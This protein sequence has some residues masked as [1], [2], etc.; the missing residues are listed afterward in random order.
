MERRKFIK[1]TGC[2]TLFVAG[3]GALA[4]CSSPENKE[5]DKLKTQALAAFNRYKEVWDFDNFWRRGNTFDACLVFA[6]AARNR[7]PDDKEVV[8]MQHDIIEMLRKNLAYFNSLDVTDMWADDFGWW[9]LM[10]LNARKHLLRTGDTK[11]AGEYFDLA[12]NKCWE[13]KKN[14]AYDETDNAIPV[15][16]GCSNGDA[17]GTSKGVKNTVTNVLLFLLSSRIYR[18][19]KEEKIS[20][21]DK[22]LDMA[23]KQWV[24]F[25]SWFKLKQ[26]EYLKKL[27]TS[28]ALVQE[29][30][31]AFIEGSDYTIKEHPPWE[32]GWVWSGDQ[33]MLLAA[34]SDML[35]LK[36]DLA[37]YLS[38]NHP[39]KKFDFKDFENRTRYLTGQIGTG[40]KNALFS[41][42]DGI[43]R[44]APF[45]A[46]F[47]P[48]HGSDYLGGR[49]IMLRYLGVP[50][51]MHNTGVN[52]KKNISATV[53]ALWQT[54]EKSKDQ[55]KPEFTTVENDKLYIQQFRK[56]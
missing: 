44:E 52:F 42:K 54:R 2:S 32:E 47:G 46:S 50:D 34:L 38:K 16:H 18:L 20:G 4:G 55:F 41:D 5:T 6:D 15:P 7:W 49:G 14:I 21:N 25:D 29:R 26:F 27:T 35:I 9:G 12:V 45:E 19:T 11:L 30:P 31:M 23:Y 3:T 56:L 40:I 22:Y 36:K 53:D 17:N 51:I 24:W 13:Y 48:V 28:G 37:E 39:E 1:I 10:A 8:K 33:G 43:V